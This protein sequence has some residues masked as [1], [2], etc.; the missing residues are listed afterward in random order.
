MWSEY[1][2][3]RVLC[4]VSIMWDQYYVGQVL[5]WSSV[6]LNQQAVLEPM[7]FYNHVN[8]MDVALSYSS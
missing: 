5:S 3:E 6:F 1:Y 7:V 2:A 8:L 4:G